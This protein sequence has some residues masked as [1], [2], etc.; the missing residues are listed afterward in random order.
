MTDDNRVGNE[1]EREECGMR[2]AKLCSKFMHNKL[3]QKAQIMRKE[4]GEKGSE[5]HN[6]L[7]YGLLYLYLMHSF[8]G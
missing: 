2:G 5:V 8:Y 4:Q 6:D 3:E 1:W 7:G